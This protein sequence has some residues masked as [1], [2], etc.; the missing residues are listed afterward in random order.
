MNDVIRCPVCN[1]FY[2]REECKIVIS[3]K[4]GNEEHCA[5]TCPNDHT[6]YLVFVN[7]S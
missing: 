4:E 7:D 6:G 5:V 2:K 3:K 1:K